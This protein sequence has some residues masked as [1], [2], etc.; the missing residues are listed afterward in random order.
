MSLH[1]R[2]DDIF[3]VHCPLCYATYVSDSLK[4]LGFI[5]RKNFMLWWLVFM[6]LLMIGVCIANPQN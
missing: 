1:G 6:T 3:S 4:F 5:K 2:L